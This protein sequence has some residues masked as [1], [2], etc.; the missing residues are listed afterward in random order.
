MGLLTW[1][2]MGFI[3]GWL[4]SIIM[5]T[6]SSQGFLMDIVLGV[7]GA[8]LGGLVM[9]LFGLPGVDGFNLYSVGVALIGAVILIWIGRLFTGR[10]MM[11]R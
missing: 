3:A 8:I 7:V 10:E 9:N 2:I 1:I 11:N 4:A 6:N 5:G